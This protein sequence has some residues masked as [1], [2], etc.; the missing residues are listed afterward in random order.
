MSFIDTCNTMKDAYEINRITTAGMKSNESFDFI[1][2][3]L[4]Y[5]YDLFHIRHRSELTE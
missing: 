3:L 2:Q 5:M 4:I 1:P